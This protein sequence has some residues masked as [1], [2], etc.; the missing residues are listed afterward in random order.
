MPH[1]LDDMPP[2]YLKAIGDVVVRWNHLE[3]LLNNI[4]GGLL[5]N[6]P[7]DIRAKIVFAH[8]A[9]PQKL[10]IMASIAE[11]YLKNPANSFLEMY[12]P[13]MPLLRQAQVDRNLVIHSMWGFFD[14]QVMR[15]LMTARGRFKFTWQPASIKEIQK[16]SKSIDAARGSLRELL[17]E[18]REEV[19]MRRIADIIEST[20]PNKHP[21]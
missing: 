9:F 3:Q 8:M 1:M 17:P 20:D 11:E 14:G 21:R 10:D 13:A 16:A 2:E 18:R 15:S 19:M 12:K 5:A 4:L 7:N 6:D